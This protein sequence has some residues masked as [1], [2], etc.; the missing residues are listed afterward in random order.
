MEKS[1][2]ELVN[3]FADPKNL[4]IE[5][6]E[7]IGGLLEEASKEE[8]IELSDTDYDSLIW[9]FRC[10]SENYNLSDEAIKDYFKKKINNKAN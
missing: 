8:K 7:Y 2:Y 5:I 4:D 3:K 10:K 6:Q 1:L 9:E